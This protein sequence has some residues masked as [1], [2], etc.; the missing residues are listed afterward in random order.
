MIAARLLGGRPKVRI[1][2]SS[3][4]RLQMKSVSAALA[5]VRALPP[6]AAAAQAAWPARPVTLIIPF[7]PGGGTDAFARPLPVQRGKQVAIDNRGG[8]C[9]TAGIK[10]WAAVTKAS[11]AKLD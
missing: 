9:G 3:P 1:G 7:P 2:V 6:G 11:G 4:G 8:A 10:R 5:A